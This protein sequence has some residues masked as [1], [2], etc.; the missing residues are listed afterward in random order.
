[1]A[2][3]RKASEQLEVERPQEQAPRLPLRALP[4]AQSG[5]QR[6]VKQWH[7]QQRKACRTFMFIAWTCK[8][9]CRSCL[10]VLVLLQRPRQHLQ[11]A[12]GSRLQ[13]Q[14]RTI[15]NGWAPGSQARPVFWAS[16][17]SAEAARQG[18][19]LS[20]AKVMQNVS[21]HHR[22]PRTLAGKAGRRLAP[23]QY[24]ACRW[25]DWAGSCSRGRAVELLQDY[26]SAA[27]ASTAAKE[28]L[29]KP[30]PQ[31]PLLPGMS[32]AAKTGSTA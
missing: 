12:H 6:A 8:Q 3:D 17:L 4:A 14:L 22:F 26:R 7:W 27:Q 2:R 32:S 20:E 21:F 9:L 23:V 1:M 5:L 24:E 28:G 15:T 29:G 31:S 30:S 19:S 18:W 25:V 11:L 16:A 13:A 10:A